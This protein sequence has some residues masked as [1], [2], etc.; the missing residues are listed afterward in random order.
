M[1]R[2][3]ARSFAAL[4]LLGVAVLGSPAAS[5]QEYPE[6]FLGAIVNP[7]NT[8]EVFGGGC[9]AGVAV[10]I[11]ITDDDTGELV[12]ST[13]VDSDESGEFTAVLD[14]GDA[15]GPAT[16]TA[17]CGDLVQTTQVVLVGAQ[18]LPVVIDP[19]VPAVDPP[20]VLPGVITP[21]TPA[22][23]GPLPRT[24]TDSLPLARLA[25]VLLAAGGI[26]VYTARKRNLR[27][28]RALA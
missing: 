18:V 3:L 1:Q 16:V 27:I 22:A 6:P 2:L 9:P 24:G 17:I 23:T 4:M 26:A 12:A 7:D 19:E 20:T 21:A 13:T 25:L 14:A 28:A 11:T 15:E 10:D 8:V 5:A